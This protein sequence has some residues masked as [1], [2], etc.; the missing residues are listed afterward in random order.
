M[1]GWPV[2][3]FFLFCERV[4]LVGVY[5]FVFVVVS[6]CWWRCL[7]CVV[8]G[9]DLEFISRSFFGF[10]AFFVFFS[11]VFLLFFSFFV[12]VVCWWFD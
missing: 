11:G 3:F 2:L 10:L 1:F 9:G 6:W 7:L 12:Y 8:L 5:S 4:C